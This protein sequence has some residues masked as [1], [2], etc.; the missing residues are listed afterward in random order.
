MDI[1]GPAPYPNGLDEK[2][3]GVD[4]EPGR[5]L[6]L[7]LPVLSLGP[8]DTL[9]ARKYGVIRM[10]EVALSRSLRSAVPRAAAPRCRLRQKNMSNPASAMTPRAE[11][12]AMTATTA[13]ERPTCWVVVDDGSIPAPGNGS[14]GVVVGRR[15]DDTEDGPTQLSVQM[16]GY[17]RLAREFLAN[18]L[19]GQ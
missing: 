9:S 19:L 14:I 10:L 2:K 5:T 8:V 15:E 3:L 16:Y 1:A 11:R 7:P 12:T 18:V 6:A 13:V 4:G 17:L